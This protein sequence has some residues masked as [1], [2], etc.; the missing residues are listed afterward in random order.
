MSV[1]EKLKKIAAESPGDWLEETSKELDKSGSRANARKV[2]LAVLRALREKNIT[3][4]ELSARMGVTRQQVAKI[5]KGKE[6]F[7]F[8]TID[9]LE[10]ALN[11]TLM[12]IAS[13]ANHYPDHP[14]AI[15][16]SANM[17]IVSE[18]KSL[19]EVYLAMAHQTHFFRY[20]TS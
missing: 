12:T 6:N 8:E 19:A 1:H 13:Q 17:P 9:K 2:A 5:V 20:P 18:I 14:P 7:T 16:S 11:I 4:V 15:L 10:K 3:Q